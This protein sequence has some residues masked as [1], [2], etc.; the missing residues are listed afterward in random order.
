MRYFSVE[1]VCIHS[2]EVIGIESVNKT[3]EL[4]TIAIPVVVLQC[5]PWTTL[6]C[7]G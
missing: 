5:V 6:S 2:L 3:V 7:V 4:R 1:Q